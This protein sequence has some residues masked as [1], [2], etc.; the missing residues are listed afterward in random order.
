MNVG[1]GAEAFD[2][3]IVQRASF[4]LADKDCLLLKYG[5]G[6]MIGNKGGRWV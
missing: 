4:S 2:I 1:E 6:C 3:A 5:I